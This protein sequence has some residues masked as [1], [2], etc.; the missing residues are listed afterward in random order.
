MY[1][2]V[3]IP[4]ACDVTCNFCKGCTVSGPTPP[5]PSSVA[6][7]PPPDRRHR[8]AA[9]DPSL[10]ALPGPCRCWSNPGSNH[11][12]RKV[13][14]QEYKF[15]EDTCDAL[16]G[17]DAGCAGC[18]IKCGPGLC[19]IKAV[20]AKPEPFKVNTVNIAASAIVFVLGAVGMFVLVT[21]GP[22]SVP[23]TPPPPCQQ[24]ARLYARN[25]Y[26]YYPIRKSGRPLNTI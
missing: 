8:L 1:T 23:S 15:E 13:N 11:E 5:A 2:G 20:R 12:Q 6:P 19:G 14:G 17:T 18:T 7:P 25:I 4:H 10:P 9:T 22:S 21:L 3:C 16:I 24:R 26:T